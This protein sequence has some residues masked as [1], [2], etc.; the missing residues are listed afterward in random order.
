MKVFNFV[1]IEY[2]SVE[3]YYDAMITEDEIKQ[4]FKEAG[5]DPDQFSELLKGV[6]DPEHPR[7]KEAVAL[8]MESDY[9]AEKWDFTE[10]VFVSLEEESYDVDVALDSVDESDDFMSIEN[11]YSGRLH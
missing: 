8:L 1:R 4:V 7:H 9:L 10:D 2:H 11:T 3:R 6:E 5:V